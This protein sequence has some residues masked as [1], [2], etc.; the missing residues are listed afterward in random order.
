MY[1]SIQNIK[2]TYILAAESGMKK[3]TNIIKKH[4]IKPSEY[5][6]LNISFDFNMLF[7]TPAK[8]QQFF[9]VFIVQQTTAYKI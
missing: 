9:I 3:I 4:R 1:V 7:H 6:I 8:I 2:P 5:T